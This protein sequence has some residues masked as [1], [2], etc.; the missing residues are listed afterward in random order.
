MIEATLMSTVIVDQSANY[1]AAIKNSVGSKQY[2]NIFAQVDGVREDLTDNGRLGCALFVSWI[3]KHFDF[4]KEAH[5]TVDGTVKDLKEHGWK[6]VSTPKEGDVLVWE[7]T[8][9]HDAAE[10][11]QHIG[12]YLGDGRAVSNSSKLREIIEH[13]WQYEGTRRCSLILSR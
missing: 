1:L 2:R 8:L 7:P 11:H 5:V 10:P 3:L 4:I 12:F 6:E 9:D 13:D